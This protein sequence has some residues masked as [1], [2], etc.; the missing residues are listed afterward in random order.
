MHFRGKGG[1][2][3]GL[4]KAAAAG[5]I[6]KIFL[7]PRQNN[8]WISVMISNLS[9]HVA[10]KA[11]ISKPKPYGR[12][13]R[14]KLKNAQ[15]LYGC[16]LAELL[17]LLLFWLKVKLKVQ[18][19][20]AAANV[21]LLGFG[22]GRAYITVE[23]QSQSRDDVDVHKTPPGCG[24]CLL[25]CLCAYHLHGAIGGAQHLQLFALCVLCAIRLWDILG[26]GYLRERERERVGERE[27]DRVF[28]F[29]WLQDYVCF[30]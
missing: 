24:W 10:D 28:G 15:W 11:T 3:F 18:R 7:L 6:W 13:I 8:Q 26:I 19:N 21:A 29:E 12:Y 5:G 14:A 2:A 27:R 22:L 25:Y 16:W 23:Y 1:V 17:L 4:I 20:A 9:P 30:G